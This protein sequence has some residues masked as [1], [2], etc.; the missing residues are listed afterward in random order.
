VIVV[1]EVLRVDNC[2]SALSGYP[3]PTMISYLTTVDNWVNRHY[4]KF[5]VPSSIAPFPSFPRFK[6]IL[7]SVVVDFEK[8]AYAFPKFFHFCLLE[9]LRV[10]ISMG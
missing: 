6:G 4:R 3:S 7:S 2:P 8:C 10:L 1:G 5:K 9:D